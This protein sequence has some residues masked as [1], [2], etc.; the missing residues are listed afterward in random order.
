MTDAVKDNDDPATP[1]LTPWPSI[2]A[3]HEGAMFACCIGYPFLSP[4]ATEEVARFLGDEESL[5]K[6]GPS[7]Y[8]RCFAVSYCWPFAC[9]CPEYFFM[10][11]FSDLASR[12]GRKLK[13]D[14]RTFGPC[15]DLPDSSPSEFSCNLALPLPFCWVGACTLCMTFAEVR[16]VT[17][18]TAPAGPESS[19]M[20]RS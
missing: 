1:E 16:K 12:V 15:G 11:Y 5:K 6:F 10:C 3:C 13:K 17:R 14:P 2:W 7:G 8:M 9:A 18:A 20:D 19:T 4:W